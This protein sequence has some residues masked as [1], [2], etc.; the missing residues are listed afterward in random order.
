MFYT[1]ASDTGRILESFP[2][3]PDPQQQAN[4]FDCEIY[5]IDG[6]HSGLSASPQPV[7]AEELKCVQAAADRVKL[8]RWVEAQGMR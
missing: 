8:E 2:V 5:I 4:Y 6:E 1:I 3:C 7:V